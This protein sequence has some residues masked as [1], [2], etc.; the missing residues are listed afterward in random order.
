MIVVDNFVKR[1]IL[2]RAIA[3]CYCG[4][5]QSAWQEQRRPPFSLSWIT[6]RGSSVAHP[7][8]SYRKRRCRRVQLCEGCRARNWSFVLDNRPLYCRWWLLAK[9]TP[10]MTRPGSWDAGATDSSAERRVGHLV[11][12]GFNLLLYHTAPLSTRTHGVWRQVRRQS[13]GGGVA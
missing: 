12:R 11:N 7:Q 6:Y 9:L 13:A 2:L 3:P 1:T 4:K 5:P 10:N 8:I